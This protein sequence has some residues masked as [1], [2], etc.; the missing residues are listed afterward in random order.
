MIP[1]KEYIALLQAVAED[2]TLQFAS[3]SNPTER[4]Y[5]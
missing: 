2:K 5:N 1:I 4:F 3:K